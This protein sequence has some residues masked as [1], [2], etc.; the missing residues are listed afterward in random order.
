MCSQLW[1]VPPSATTGSGGGLAAG[2]TYQETNAALTYTGN[3]LSDT[4]SN[5]SGGTYRYT[6]DPNGRI[7]FTFTGSKLIIIRQTAFNRGPMQVCIDGACQTVQ[8]YTDAVMWQQGVSF[9]VAA[10]THTVEIRNSSASFID[11]DAIRI[12]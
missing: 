7:S 3:W 4:N 1:S 2:A 11:I 8:N 6:N 9:T 10:G 5:A 12:E